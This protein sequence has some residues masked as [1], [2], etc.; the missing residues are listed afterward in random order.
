MRRYQ[1]E[2]NGKLLQVVCNQC[3]KEMKVENGYLKEGCFG[4][5]YV[6]GYFSSRDGIRHRFDLCEDCY[7]KMIQQFA[8]PVEEIRERELL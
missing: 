5:D 8:V 2:K 6:F 1:K 7:N 4:A 3:K